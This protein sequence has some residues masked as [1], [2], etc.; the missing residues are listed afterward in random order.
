[1]LGLDVSETA[2]MKAKQYYGDQVVFKVIKNNDFK[3]VI[4]KRKFDLTITLETL[5]YIRNWPKT[6]KDI[7]MFSAHLYMS[8]YIPSRPIGFVKSFDD[9][10]NV[11]SRYFHIRE[12]L[13]YN[14]E[15]IFLFLENKK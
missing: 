1:M 10:T 7:S 4:G 8:L 3:P 14:D 11:S 12:K 9:L 15:S 13:I 2:I 6:I 5:S